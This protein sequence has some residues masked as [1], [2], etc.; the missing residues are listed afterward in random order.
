MKSSADRHGDL[1]DGAIASLAVSAQGPPVVLDDAGVTP[2]TNSRDGLSLA[3]PVG[4]KSCPRAGIN[5]WIRN[6]LNR[7]R[8]LRFVAVWKSLW[9]R[10]DMAI[11]AGQQIPVEFTWRFFPPS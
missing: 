4:A 10:S 2:T 5:P 3:F 7:F 9:H 11:A 6:Q 8:R 1:R